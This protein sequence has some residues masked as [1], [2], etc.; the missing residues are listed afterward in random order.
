MKTFGIVSMAAESGFDVG[1]YGTAG[2]AL[3][4]EE[5][6]PGLPRLDVRM[7]LPDASAHRAAIRSLDAV[8]GHVVVRPR[9]PGAVGG[10]TL[11]I[12]ISAVLGDL[13][14]LEVELE[15]LARE[16]GAT[17]VVGGVGL[18]SGTE[19][20][21]RR[22]YDSA[23]LLGGDGSLLDRYDKSHLVPFGEYLP[24]GRILGKIG[25]SALTAQQGFGYTPGEGAAVLNLGPVGNALPLICYELIFPQDLR[26]QYSGELR[27]NAI[28]RISEYHVT[29][30]ADHGFQP[31]GREFHGGLSSIAGHPVFHF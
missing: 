4:P 13:C 3:T 11:A 18:S 28:L 20:G 6:L 29:D 26:S 17:F 19:R 23:F 31:T 5:G 21:E 14:R 9:K 24:L 10:W 8:V 22:W 15:D 25:L 2:E 1:L 16:T 27:S 12:R 30:G 7:P